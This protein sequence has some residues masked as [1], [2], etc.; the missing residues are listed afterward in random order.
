MRIFQTLSLA[1]NVKN[2]IYCHLNLRRG[3]FHNIFRF[4]YFCINIT[5]KEICPNMPR[6]TYGHINSDHLKS[7]IVIACFHLVVI[8]SGE[9]F[10]AKRSS[11]EK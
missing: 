7:M 3:L 6:H 10:G 5:F 2:K 4:D 1:E 8:V 11:L 9:P